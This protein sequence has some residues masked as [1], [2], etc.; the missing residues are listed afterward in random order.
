MKN[1]AVTMFIEKRG[2]ENVFAYL[3]SSI[4]MSI[5]NIKPKK[6]ILA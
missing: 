2:L 3:M 5:T 4:L 1:K 6:I